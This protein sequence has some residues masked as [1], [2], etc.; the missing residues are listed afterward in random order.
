MEECHQRTFVL[1]G[2]ATGS[3]YFVNIINES[4]CSSTAWNWVEAKIFIRTVQCPPPK[5]CFP[6]HPPILC[7]V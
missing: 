1:V 3:N 7:T 5:K 2:D 4:S 6:A